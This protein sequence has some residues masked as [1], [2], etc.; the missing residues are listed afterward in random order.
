[1]SMAH[2]T[3]IHLA[4]DAGVKEIRVGVKEF[5]CQGARDPF[6]HPH[7]YLDMGKDTDVICP[8]CSTRFVYDGA[9]KASQTLPEGALVAA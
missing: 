7:I 2:S 5:R 8:Y 1:M 6:D 3:V 4:N 9:L